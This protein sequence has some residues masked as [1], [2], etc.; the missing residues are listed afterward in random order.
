MFAKIYASIIFA[1]KTKSKDENVDHS[2][3]PSAQRSRVARTVKNSISLNN[4]LRD[5]TTTFLEV[6]P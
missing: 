5:N 1:K 3:T 4:S 6:S 2:L